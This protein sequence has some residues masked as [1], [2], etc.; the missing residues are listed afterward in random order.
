MKIRITKTPK[1]AKQLA[2][3]YEVCK[4]TVY[5]AIQAQRKDDKTIKVTRVREGTSGP[6][7]KAWF[8]E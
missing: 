1:T 8:R 4:L 5:R 6:K 3:E 7:S 2:E